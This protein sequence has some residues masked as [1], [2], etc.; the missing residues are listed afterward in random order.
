LTS[1]RACINIAAMN[2]KTRALKK[3]A[4]H[5]AMRAKG[6]DPQR[7]AG[8]LAEEAKVDR[9]LVGRYCTGEVE[10]G[11]E[12]APKIATALGVPVDVIL[13]GRAAA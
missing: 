10:V 7:D 8:R 3:A 5:E 4:L 1:L 6:W 9:S 2:K 13:Y 12:N 11:V